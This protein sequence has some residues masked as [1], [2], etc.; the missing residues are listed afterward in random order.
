MVYVLLGQGFEETEAVA[1]IDL[2]RRAGIEVTTVGVTGK[3]VPGSHGIPVQADITMSELNPEDMEMI[4]LPGGMGG[5]RSLLDSTQALQAV[6][7][8]WEHGKFVAAICAAPTIL[9]R[10]HITDNKNATCYPGCE[11]NM[12]SARMIP[13]VPFVRDGRLITGTSAGCA[14]PFGLALIAALK[15]QDTADAIAQQVVIR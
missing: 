9:A 8:A 12:G 7:Y 11:E 6:S 10:L 2:M 1:P 13:N 15:G 14:V 4:V 5:V 3:I